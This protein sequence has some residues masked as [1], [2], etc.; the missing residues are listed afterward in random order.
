MRLLQCCALYAR[1]PVGHSLCRLIG[2]H[3]LLQPAMRSLRLAA[4]V[5]LQSHPRLLLCRE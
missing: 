2:G 5:L 4:T 3:G 1:P